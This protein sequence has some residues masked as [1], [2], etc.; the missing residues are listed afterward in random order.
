[1]IP[2]VKG[3]SCRGE[4]KGSYFRALGFASTITENSPVS[5]ATSLYRFYIV[6]SVLPLCDRLSKPTK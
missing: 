2:W 4:K 3:N 6:G 1:M 5:R